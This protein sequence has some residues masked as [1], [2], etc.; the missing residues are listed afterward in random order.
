ME[1]SLDLLKFILPEML[2]EHFDLVRHTHRNEEL[3]L[4]FEERNVVPKEVI[5]PNVIAHGFHKEITIEDFPLRGNTVYLHVRRRRWL[6][7]ETRQIIQ[8]DWNLVAQG[9]RMTGE[10]AAFLKE[11]SRY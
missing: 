1:L 4:Y 10:F 8:R 7:K 5:N 6:D 9:T 2:V 3:H 11:I